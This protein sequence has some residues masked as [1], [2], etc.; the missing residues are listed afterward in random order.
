[1]KSR[2]L[3]SMKVFSDLQ[4][5]LFKRIREDHDFYSDLM[6]KLILQGIIKLFE[7]KIKIRCLEEDVSLVRKLIP[8]IT[9]EFKKQAQTELEIDFELQLELDEKIHLA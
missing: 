3:A 1:M 7:H 4:Y 9:D 2:N 5:K 8:Q 6:R